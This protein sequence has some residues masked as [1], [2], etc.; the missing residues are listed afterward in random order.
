MRTFCPYS[1]LVCLFAFVVFLWCPSRSFAQ[2]E[3]GEANAKT[4]EQGPQELEKEEQAGEE[5]Q[6][7]PKTQD[8]TAARLAL[9]EVTVTATKS[10]RPTFD[11]PGH[12]S[13]IDREEIERLQPQDI[14]DLLRY[15]PGS[16]TDKPTLSTPKIRLLP[17]TD[18]M[19]GSPL[20]HLVQQEN[21]REAQEILYKVLS[22]AP[23][24]LS[25]R[26]LLAQT[27]LA[28]EDNGRALTELRHIGTIAP[29]FPGLKPALDHVL[30]ALGRQ[31]VAREG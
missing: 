10:E 29:A 2:E 18:A 19:S 15:Q 14:T 31:T 1:F 13:V 23:D 9:E 3:S 7:K 30:Q 12:V 4:S 16:S 28:Q 5:A 27:F 6:E 26:F 21:Y 22:L 17:N 20:L 24:S 11:T 25:G 8:R